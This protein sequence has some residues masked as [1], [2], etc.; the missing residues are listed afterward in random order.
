MKKNLLLSLAGLFF[1]FLLVACGGNNTDN[2]KETSADA[3]SDATTEDTSSEETAEP[4]EIEFW[5]AM[6]GPHEEAINGFVEDFNSEHENITVKP[7]NQGSYDD[8]EQKVMAAAKAGNLPTLSQ[9]VTNVI[10]EYIANDFVAPLNDFIED[11]EIGLSDEELNDYVDVFKQSSQWDGTYY[12]LPFSKSTRILFYNTTMLEENGLEAPKTWEDVRNIAETVTGD[13][14]VGMGFENSY[15]SEFQAILKQMGGTYIDK[16]THEA[17]FG[18]KEGVQAMTMIKDMIDEGIARTAGED[19]YMSNPFGRG[20][21]AM[22]IGSSA[23]I[24]HVA[25]AAE[26]NIEWSATTMPT[27]D[28]EAATTFAGNDIV[29]FNQAETAEQEA[30]WQ[31]MKY[32]TSPE[33]SADW[34][35]QSGYLPVRYSA[36]ETEDYQA[37]VE[38]NPA[39]EA[40]PKQFDTGFFI[41]RVQGGDAV[42]NI[43]LEELDKILLD[44]KTVEEGL[45]DAQEQANE[46][47]QQ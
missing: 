27:L 38:E 35:M 29:M 28:G 47:L 41:A 44:E 3:E 33:V 39:Y 17:K 43:V 4:V 36:Q 12:S 24:P 26:G 7:V 23:G 13:G 19:N 1:L 31:F 20:D 42:R 22:Y 11:S 40:G 32:L 21:V 45:S 16:E 37:Y 5:H 30:A 2:S 25:S 34:A 8:L 15:E 14:I 6:S 18:S 46:E 10:P 9:A